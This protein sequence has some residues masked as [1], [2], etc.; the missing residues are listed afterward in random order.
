MSVARLVKYDAQRR[1]EAKAVAKSKTAPA[2]KKVG[3][4]KKKAE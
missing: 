2:K 4:P 3:R 1:G